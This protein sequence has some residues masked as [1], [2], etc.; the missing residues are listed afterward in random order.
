MK[1]ILIALTLVL[2]SG[3]LLLATGQSRT[4]SRQRLIISQYGTLLDILDAKGKSRY[5]KLKSDGF[6]ITYKVNGKEGQVA[7]RGVTDAEGLVP[8]K[9][10]Y[11]GRTATVSVMT[12]DKM[13]QITSYFILN[14]IRNTLTILRRITNKSGMPLQLTSTRHYLDPAPLQGF[15]S[16]RGSNRGFL[17]FAETPFQG[18]GR[19][20]VQGFRGDRYLGNLVDVGDLVLALGSDCDPAICPDQEPPCTSGSGSCFTM[21]QEVTQELNVPSQTVISGA[22]DLANCPCEPLEKSA[23]SPCPPTEVDDVVRYSSQKVKI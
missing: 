13:L 2:F 6:A 4:G 19:N 9:I 14:E 8:G 5:G 7:A 16:H 12:E 23:K 17:G 11:Y 15:G 18:F 3:S 21:S 20:S 10:N 22:V 1:R